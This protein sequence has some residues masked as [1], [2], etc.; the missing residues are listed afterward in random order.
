MGYYTGESGEDVLGE[1]DHVGP[2]LQG[3]RAILHV[4]G[5]DG[6][7]CKCLAFGVCGMGDGLV[8]GFK[9]ENCRE[10]VA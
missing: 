1:S 5:H 7:V 2:H 4:P 10:W 3:G 6:G 9:K 8:E